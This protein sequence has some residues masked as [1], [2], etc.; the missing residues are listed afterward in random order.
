MLI[1]SMTTLGRHFLCFLRP[2][3]FKLSLL[4]VALVVFLL[5]V[6]REYTTKIT[7]L[8]SRGTPMPYLVL[9]GCIL[10]FH[11][12]ITVEAFYVVALLVDVVLWYLIVCLVTAGYEKVLSFYMAKS[13]KFKL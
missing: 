2:N 8:E 1:G 5:S 6:D 11:C 7:W 9:G 12:G 10:A 13:E 4:G 3:R